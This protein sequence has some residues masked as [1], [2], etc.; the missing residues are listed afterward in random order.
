M[1]RVRPVE[2]RV[3][4]PQG[5]VCVREGPPHRAHQNSG[6]CLP[7]RIAYQHACEV[8]GFHD[9]SAL[10]QGDSLP[11]GGGRQGA[12]GE[13]LGRGAE[14]VGTEGGCGAMGEA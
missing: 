12:G 9:V 6:A 3:G 5:L 8:E 2:T 7:A 4:P 1:H 10:R 14:G 13:A 11:G